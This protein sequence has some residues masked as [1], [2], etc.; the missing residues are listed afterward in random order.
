MEHLLK[1]SV[2]IAIFYVCY[3]LFLQ[4]ETFFEQNR[5]FLL[6]GLITA[7][8][9]P[10]VVIPI[11]VEATPLNLD[12]LVF[13]TTIPVENIEKPFSILDYLPIIYG[14][15][16]GIFFIRF[17]I[18]FA[19]L[20]L[21]IFKN[22]G[23]K[24]GGYTF[25]KTSDAISPF[26][27]FN[28][29][30]Y[31]PNQFSDTEL[32]Q[33]ITHE[34]VHASQKH[35]FD[36]LLTHISCILLWFNPFVWFYNKDLKQN[37]EFIAD[38]VT[39]NKSDCKKS[40]QYTLLKTSMPSHQMALSNPFYNSLIKKR[41]VMLHK[42]KS[43]KINLIKYALVIPVLGLFLMSFNTETVYVSKNTTQETLAKKDI[44][45]VVITKIFSENDFDK[46]K[47]KL[48]TEGYTAKFK[49]IKRNSENEIIAIKIEVTSKTSN[50]NFNLD[51]DEAIS[52][53]KIA[54]EDGEI[55]ISNSSSSKEKHV[56][57]ITKDGETH[58]MN[59]SNSE[60]NV[61]IFK[62]GDSDI[63]SEE[64]IIIKNG[65]T[66]HVEKSL[67]KKAV[68]LDIDDEGKKV[69]KVVK[70][71]NNAT[72]NNASW[73]SSDKEDEKVVFSSKTGSKVK[74]ISTDEKA[75]LIILDGKE[76]DNDE[77]NSI[78]PNTIEKVD[79]LKGENA[80][81]IHGDKGK[82]GVILITS[83][84]DSSK[85]TV[86]LSGEALYK[87]DGKEVKK[88]DVDKLNP[89]DIASINVLKDETATKNYGEKGKNGVIE[90][91]TKKKM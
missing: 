80:I 86:K 58:T 76:I 15:G 1:T 44:I 20:G 64:K 50:A 7:F 72:N 9:L 78:N 16:I 84:N 60:S 52:P 81:R 34:K 74:I 69:H 22:K 3:K 65:D 71:R 66:L 11:Y 83:K 53:I 77:M 27:F 14:I 37:L 62:S 35:S 19:S 40:Y 6:A 41:I 25:I 12:N 18:Q 73:I 63:T 17:L 48:E 38:K 28:W 23:E 75:P 55:S 85:Y 30:V 31:N 26:S 57:F 4:R 68:I 67:N 45:V 33:I 2:I 70:I 47:T 39:A 8:L 13:N 89:D 87:I 91:T 54:I 51:G 61:L 5:W 32:N 88:E 42:S 56:V 49:G 24:V 59:N 21:V 90:I 29:I 10:Y 79:V 36:I 82:N 46:L 43:N